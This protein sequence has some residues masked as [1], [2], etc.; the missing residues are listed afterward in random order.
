MAGDI[1]AARHTS[2]CLVLHSRPGL[3]DV[4]ALLNSG[5]MLRVECKKGP[6]GTAR[7]SPEYPLLREAL[8]Q[9]VTVAEVRDDDI[10]AAAVPQSQKS[11]ALA[12][13]WRSA[14]LIKRLGIRILTVD[15]HGCVDGF[16]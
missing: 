16:E 13:S 14:P 4:V 3:G 1:S 15:R 6:L 11:L 9:L 8:G 7:S 10:L 2:A 12:A 5:Q